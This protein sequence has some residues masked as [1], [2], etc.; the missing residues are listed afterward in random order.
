MPT[1][2]LREGWVESE[3][4]HTLSAEAE[5]FFLRLCL[6]ADDYG[7]YHAHLTLLRSGLFPLR[8][9]L[10]STDIAAW[11]AECEKAGVLRCYEVG[12][13]RYVEITK[14]RQQRRAKSKFPDPPECKADAKQPYAD[15]KQ[16]YTDAK[17]PYTGDEQPPASA[18]LGVVVVG[19]GGGGVVVSGQQTKRLH[20]IPASPEE[21]IAYGKTINPPVP[22]ARCRDFWNHYEA[23]A[24]TNAD[25]EIFWV[26][27]GDTV[28]TNWKAKLPQFSAGGNQAAGGALKPNPRNAGTYGD[29]SE[30]GRRIAD[31]IAKQAKERTHD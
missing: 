18:H 9:T 7:R 6:K 27:S 29:P 20:N 23:Q 11:L 21:V 2:I 1:R 25:G 10:R 16:P 31:K 13:K 26:T 12:G 19:G 24:K 28:I 5:R 4:V 8:E 15:A 17:Q 14:F 30:Q 22:E 3:A